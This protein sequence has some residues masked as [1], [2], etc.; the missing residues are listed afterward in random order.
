M[1][2]QAITFTVE[3]L[4]TPIG[5]VLILTDQEGLLRAVDFEDYESRM[6][7]LLDRHY[8]RAGWRSAEAGAASSARRALAA[9]FE[10]EIGAIDALATR[11][12]GSSFQQRVWT[13]LR[14]VEAGA[15]TSYGALAVTIGQPSAVR[16]V[17]LANGAN[18]IAIVVPCHRVVGSNGSLTG[19]GGGLP[20]KRWL[21]DHEARHA[22]LAVARPGY[23]G[24]VVPASPR[25]QSTTSCALR[26]GGKTG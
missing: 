10:G 25:S 19:Y 11:T 26:S 4:A 16:A 23:D 5:T 1:K 3:R 9:F 2:Q 20:R 14:G 17:G 7:R 8:G 24:A 6:V 18:P 12:N 15:T 13:A 21:I 22:G